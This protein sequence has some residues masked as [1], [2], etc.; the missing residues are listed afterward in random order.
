MCIRDSG[1]VDRLVAAA[2]PQQGDRCAVLLAPAHQG[3]AV[4]PPPPPAQPDGA[5]ADPGGE[6][7]AFDGVHALGGGSRLARFGQGDAGLG[8]D[9]PAHGERRVGARPVVGRPAG[10]A[11][12][13]QQRPVRLGTRRPAGFDARRRAVL[14]GALELFDPVV[15]RVQQPVLLVDHALPHRRVEEEG[16]HRLGLVRG[17]VLQAARGDLHPQD[18]VVGPAVSGG[19]AAVQ[20]CLVEHAQAASD[21]EREGVLQGAERSAGF[22]VPVLPLVGVPV[23]RAVQLPQLDA[24]QPAPLQGAADQ[25]V[26]GALGRAH[27][28][29][30][31]L[32]PAQEVPVPG[33]RG[34]YGEQ[35]QL[36]VHDEPQDE[37][38]L[39][40]HAAQARAVDR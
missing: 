34:V 27:Q 38:A 1:R 19:G 2:P 21:A 32:Q 36:A 3:P 11:D 28:Q 40:G 5:G 24:A 23:L 29:R 12:G 30:A 25:G 31:R 20:R 35:V 4:L 33:L 22:G 18:V 6:C 7:D 37:R 16:A 10:A 9:Q 13:G 8:G 15:Q 39:Q 14:V 17:A 26:L